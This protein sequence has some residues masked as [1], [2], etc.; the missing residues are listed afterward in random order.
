MTN[1]GGDT[2]LTLNV[3]GVDPNAGPA[4][5]AYGGQIGATGQANFGLVKT[6]PATQAIFGAGNLYTGG[7]TITGGAIAVSA[8][9]A[10]GDPTGGITLNG[11]ALAANFGF[12][13]SATPPSPSARS[14]AAGP[15]RS[16]SPTARSS[17]TARSPTRPAGPA[18][19]SRPTPAPCSW[20][21]RQSIPA[22]PRS[23]AAPCSS[24]PTTP[25]RPGR[26]S[27]SA[28]R[29]RAGPTAAASST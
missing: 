28:P 1:T 3:S 12:T 17:T 19:W 4:N 20:A 26:L 24:G 9:G 2:S 15:G 27:C 7:T 5:F 18:P 11:G 25:C 14:A 22:T 6:G 10:L 23:A 29:S 16:T 21:G 8:D 13:L